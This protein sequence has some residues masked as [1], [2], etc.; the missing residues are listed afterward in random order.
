[1]LYS[2]NVFSQADGSLFSRLQAIH[3]N[4]ID[5]Y[6]IDGFEISSQKFDSEFSK[7]NIL[8]HF[9]RDGIKEA[10]L[11]SADSVL[12]FNNIHVEKTE[13]KVKGVVVSNSYY[14]LETT[15]KKLTGISFSVMNKSDRDFER[16]FVTL[17]RNN[18]VPKSVF[19]SIDIDSL[20]FAGRKIVLEGDCRYMGVNNVQCPS[21]GQMSWSIHNTQDDASR[22]LDDHW[23]ILSQQKGGK[24][25]LD[26]MV[27]VV[28]EGRETTAK[29]MVYGLKGINSLL[30]KMDGAKNLIVY[31][32][33]CPVKNNFISCVMSFW[34]IDNVN[35]NGL[36]RL[37]EKVMLLK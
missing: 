21:N 16:H 10:D 36:P 33:A 34:D 31:A 12:K 23:K 18:A 20:N 11:N 3:N 15:E 29:K 8:K 27:N 4:K 26:T 22:T 17:I 19:N 5:F 9:K 28:F 6:N 1:M 13:E 2:I 25:L 37:L 14:F 32:V 24:V 30:I 35:Q 7:K